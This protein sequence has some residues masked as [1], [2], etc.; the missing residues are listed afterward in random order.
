MSDL[1]IRLFLDEDV[2]VLLGQLLRVRGYDV[3]AAIDA[4]RRGA[5]DA[6]QLAFAAAQER[7]LLTHNRID[8]E[9][10]AREW[11]AAGRHHSGMF[12]AVRRRP[13]DILRRLLV[14][15]D[16]VTADEMQD[17]LLYL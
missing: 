7:A 12:I 10:L 6:E 16:Q 17:Q 13:H 14:I 2:D 8:F 4:G 5:S 3:V 1:F 9:N 15:L 11:L